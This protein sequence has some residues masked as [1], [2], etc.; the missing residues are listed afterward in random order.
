M[1]LKDKNKTKEKTVPSL[2]IIASIFFFIYEFLKRF[3]SF[4]K[5]GFDLIK[6]RKNIKAGKNNFIL[7]KR[8]LEAGYLNM[9]KFR[10]FLARYFHPHYKTSYCL[11]YIYFSQRKLKKALFFTEESIKLGNT[12]PNIT[13]IKE[14]II[15]TQ[16]LENDL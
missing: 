4:Y 5:N 7:G 16:E 8:C 12:H 2:I 9:A 10:F 15:K 13:I 14:K 11:A 1:S 3:F 6:D